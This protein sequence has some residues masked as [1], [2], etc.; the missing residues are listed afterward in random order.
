MVAEEE[1]G[2]ELVEVAVACNY[3]LNRLILLTFDFTG[4]GECI[5]HIHCLR[6]GKG[7]SSSI[8]TNFTI[9]TE[10]K[11][12]FLSFCFGN[13]VLRSRSVGSVFDFLI[14][15]DKRTVGVDHSILL[16]KRRMFKFDIGLAYLGIAG[17][18]KTIYCR[19]LRLLVRCFFSRRNF[20][21]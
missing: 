12:T 17:N 3:M 20:G 7:D 16:K 21:A 4:I 10:P 11:L 1:A 14:R 18:V 9:S 8:A 2:V 5:P 19:I 15:M 13:G 6:A